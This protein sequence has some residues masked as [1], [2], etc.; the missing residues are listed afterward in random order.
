MK[1][2][3]TLLER[4]EHPIYGERISWYVHF[5]TYRAMITNHAVIHNIEEYVSLAYTIH[6]EG[7]LDKAI[8][9]GWIKSYQLVRSSPKYPFVIKSIRLHMYPQDGRVIWKRLL[10]NKC[11]NNLHHFIQ[12]LTRDSAQSPGIVDVPKVEDINHYLKYNIDG[13]PR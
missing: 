5:L 10:G 1:P 9:Y 4:I 7:L 2:L 8:K 13:T 3:P 12:E 11:Y 6:Y